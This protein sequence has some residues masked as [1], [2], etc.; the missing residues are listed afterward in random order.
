MDYTGLQSFNYHHIIYQEF[1]IKM[2][3]FFG[4]HDNIIILKEW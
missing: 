2:V 1:Q 4:V 3:L